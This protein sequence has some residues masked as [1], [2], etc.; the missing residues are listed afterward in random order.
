VANDAVL[1]RVEQ[2][3]EQQLTRRVDGAINNTI[4]GAI[5]QVVAVPDSIKQVG[6]QALTLATEVANIVSSGAALLQAAASGN[7]GFLT[8][9]ALA[10]LTASQ[11]AAIKNLGSQMDSHGQALGGAARSYATTE[12]SIGR[13]AQTQLANSE[14]MLGSTATTLA[15]VRS[16]SAAAQQQVNSLTTN[17]REV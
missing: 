6:Q 15:T 14:N 4:N 8:V 5:G 2:A 1:G 3:A 17:A 11:I 13:T 16:D 10:A 9:P 12:D 7:M